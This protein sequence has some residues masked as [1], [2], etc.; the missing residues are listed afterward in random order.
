[1]TKKRSYKVLWNVFLF[2]VCGGSLIYGFVQQQRVTKIRNENHD[3]KVEIDTL[4]VEIVKFEEEARQ[5][6]ILA[7]RNAE[8]ARENAEI[9]RKNEERAREN[10]EKAK[11]LQSTKQRQ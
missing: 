6:Q 7:K 3:L 4:K 9:A 8:M 10:M 2:V 11:K 1:M 5:Q